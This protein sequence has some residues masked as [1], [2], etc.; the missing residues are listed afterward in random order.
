MLMDPRDPRTASLSQAAAYIPSR[1]LT[2]TPASAV[3]SGVS[4]DSGGSGAPPTEWSD[5]EPE[6]VSDLSAY[7]NF[8]LV[9][10]FC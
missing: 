4:S 3:S 10:C 9:I 5:D 2:S 7:L 8:T 6:T 1:S